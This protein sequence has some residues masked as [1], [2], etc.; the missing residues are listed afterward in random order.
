MHSVWPEPDAITAMKGIIHQLLLV[1]GEKVSW[2]GAGAEG[3]GA[4]AGGV[5]GRGAG[6]GVEGR[7]TGTEGREMETE[8]AARTTDT[9]AA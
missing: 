5:T 4:T 1:D 8:G 2:L 3:F 6:G 7:T 9:D